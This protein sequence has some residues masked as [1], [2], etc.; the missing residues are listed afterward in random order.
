[1]MQRALS[2]YILLAVAILTGCDGGSMPEELRAVDSMV[3]SHP[4]S[5]LICLDRLAGQKDSWDKASRMRYELLKA[6]AQNKA[7][8]PFTSDSIATIFT[9]YYDSHGTPN[10]RLLAH[11]LL[12]CV[13]RD[14]GETP[15]AVDCFK[16]AI[17]T[18]DTT[19]E[20]C[21]Y[22]TLGAAYAQMA[23][24]YHRQLLLTYEIEARRHA[25]DYAYLAKDTFTAIYGQ[26]L[27]AGAYILLNQNKKAEDILKKTMALFKKHGYEKAAARSSNIMMALYVDDKEKLTE[28]KRLIDIYE[29]ESGLFDE[30]H[31]LPPNKRQFYYYKGKY[32]EGI[33]HL[34]SAEY[35]Y[36]KR[37]Y[38]DMP[39]VAKDPMYRGLLSVFKKR[40]QA[41]SIAKYAQLFCEA[42]DSSIAIK[43][44]ELTAQMAACYNYTYYQ[45]ESRNNEAKAYRF[46]MAVAIVTAIFLIIVLCGYIRWERYK[47]AQLH[48]QEEKNKLQRE[49]TDRLKAQ[50][51]FASIRYAEKIQALRELDE[52]HRYTSAQYEAETEKL[53][54]EIETLKSQIQALER[55]EEIAGWRNTS[56]PF[57]NT[58]IIKRV[59]FIIDNPPKSL[60]DG[61]MAQ[62]VQTVNEYYPDLIVDLANSVGSNSHGTYVGI[63]TAM[64]VSP[65]DITRLI[66]IS[67]SQVSNI[68][69][70]LNRLLFNEKTARTLS[71]NL[72][73]KYHLPEI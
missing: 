56:I 6:K 13:Y 68:R 72:R 18:A 59:R 41:D 48:R 60:S 10:D 19:A 30:H 40:H 52:R 7:Y 33:G 1:M 62:L 69:L 39:P 25:S 50:F 15:R 29:Q 8:I 5:A 23:Y 73:N 2:L 3:D 65:S 9:D 45:Q 16:D 22:R 57:S 66:G 34:D 36:R 43:D 11:Y 4:D 63:L 42:N 49:E 64:N 21:D 20:D 55:R 37:Y 54:G 28:L 44:R 61:D 51:A 38:P 14:R 71:A 26:E 70:N 53:T 35:Y 32:Y 17:A 27:V 31:E 47:R 67:S 58:G 24:V 12:G 46:K